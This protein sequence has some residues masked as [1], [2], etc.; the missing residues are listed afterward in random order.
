MVS[1]CNESLFRVGCFIGQKKRRLNKSRRLTAR[2]CE[3]HKLR[4][5]HMLS[6]LTSKIGSY[7]FIFFMGIKIKIANEVVCSL[8]YHL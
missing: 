6:R 8:L 5:S 4:P 7:F 3:S 1:D 2:R